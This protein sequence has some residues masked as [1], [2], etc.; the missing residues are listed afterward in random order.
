[1]HLACHRWMSMYWMQ[2]RTF[3]GEGLNKCELFHTILRRSM[4]IEIPVFI[5]NK[6]NVLPHAH[7]RCPVLLRR[8]FFFPRVVAAAMPDLVGGG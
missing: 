8:F 3:I 7:T 1:M 5:C 6:K 4:I 2:R